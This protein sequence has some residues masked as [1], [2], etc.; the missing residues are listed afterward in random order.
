MKYLNEVFKNNRKKT[1][2]GDGHEMDRFSIL[3]VVCSPLGE[4]YGAT[5]K[6]M[7]YP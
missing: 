4:Q 1:V 2:G 7:P 5:Y 3:L 6:D